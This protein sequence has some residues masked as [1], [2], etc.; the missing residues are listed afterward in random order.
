MGTILPINSCCG[1]NNPTSDARVVDF[2]NHIKKI[3]EKKNLKQLELYS[4]LTKKKEDDLH[5]SYFYQN[6]LHLIRE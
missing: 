5:K 4:K 1:E 3:S 6:M 2:T